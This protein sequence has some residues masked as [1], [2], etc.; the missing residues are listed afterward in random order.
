MS[1]IRAAFVH[2]VLTAKL[3]LAHAC[4]QFQVS[5]KTGYKW[6]QRFRAHPQEPLVDRSHRPCTSPQRTTVELEQQVLDVRDRFGWGAA[7]IHA[8]LRRQQPLLPW[9]SARTVH[10][11]L[12][13][14][15]R[16]DA[17]PPAVVADQRFEREQPHDLW[18]CDFK[19]PI[20][21]Q[22]RKVHPFTL[23][24]DHSRYLLALEVCDDLTMK[25]AFD[26]LWR[27]MGEVGMPAAILADNGFGSTHGLKTLSWFDSRLV[28]LH[29]QP[30]HGRAYHPQTQG[31]VERLHGTLES[32]L[33][34]RVRRDLVGHF[35]ADLTA[36]RT[37][38]YNPLR[39]HEALGMATPLSRFRASPR[40]R[41]AKLPEL[42]YP[43][44]A[45]LRK[46]ARCGE[47]SFRNHCLLAGG[48]LAGEL[49]R[50]EEREHEIALF[51]GWK[52]IRAIARQH[53][54]RGGKFN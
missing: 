16:V 40:P 17:P 14:H 6:L 50:V 13:R 35:Q 34:P 8:L 1:E 42:E 2:A 7:K 29:I 26:V 53:L 45:I 3:P 33:F 46:V 21:V 43:A 37:E 4:R 12:R 54:V 36:W 47:I 28:R 18:Q 30:L 32:E 11:I 49:V 39:P 19:G 23:L 20:E 15:R 41:P 27:V 51:Y 44:G 52:E 5:R 38:V 10:A 48:G 25:T 24:D 31:K 9:P 22:R